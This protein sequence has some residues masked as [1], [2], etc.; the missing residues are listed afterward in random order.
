MYR[1]LAGAYLV[2]DVAERRLPLPSGQFD[3]TVMLRDAQFDAT[4]A[5]VY[6]EDDVMNRNT[7]LVNGKP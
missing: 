2:S 3:V 7:L 6:T 5:L 1:G 4:G